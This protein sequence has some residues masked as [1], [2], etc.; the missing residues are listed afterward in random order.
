MEG[1]TTLPH[2]AVVAGS[3]LD[4]SGLLDRVRWEKP[5][6]A[7]ES[8]APASVAGHT[9]VFLEGICGGLPLIVQQGRRHFYEGLSY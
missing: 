7:F 3:G 8:L 5:F 2:M 4:L 9:G 6:T 1:M